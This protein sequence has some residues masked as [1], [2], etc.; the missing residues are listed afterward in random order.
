MD[1]HLVVAVRGAGCQARQPRPSK[2]WTRPLRQAGSGFGRTSQA[3][4]KGG[5]RASSPATPVR[6]EIPF[7]APARG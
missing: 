5:A 6:N 3:P 7:A 4:V 1:A 2:S